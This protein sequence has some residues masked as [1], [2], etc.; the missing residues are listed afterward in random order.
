MDIAGLYV[1]K[2]SETASR[3]YCVV[4]T[5][6][7]LGYELNNAPQAITVLPGAYAQVDYTLSIPNNPAKGPSLPLTGGQGT[8]LFL[9]AGVAIIGA[10]GGTLIF[11][12]ARA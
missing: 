11:R 4:E 2:N 1:G 12:K 9:I 7:P 8:M 10:A 3:V 5:E 6:A